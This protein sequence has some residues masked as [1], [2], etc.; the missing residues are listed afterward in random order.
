MRPLYSAS[1]FELFAFNFALAA[2]MLIVAGLCV[3]WIFIRRPE[4][5]RHL[6]GRR[7]AG[8]RPARLAALALMLIAQLAGILVL[9]D[10]GRALVSGPQ[11]VTSPLRARYERQCGARMMRCYYAEF[12][13]REDVFLRVAPFA[14]DLMVEGRCYKTTYF[15]SLFDIYPSGY[16]AEIVQMP[17]ASCAS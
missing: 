11:V 10:A 8:R 2:M 9:F 17:P 3:A 4:W 6:T 16:I 13:A 1:A 15:R 7:P 5:E 12:S 14:Y